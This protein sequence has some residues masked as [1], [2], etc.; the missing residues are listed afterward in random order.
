MNITF[1]GGGNMAGA[2]IGGLLHQG[3]D[4]GAIQVVEIDAAARA[5]LEREYRIATVAAVTAAT[6]RA[7]CIVLAV[8]PQHVREV[9]RLLK[10][11]LAAQLVVSIAAGIRLAD[12]GRWLGG[13]PRLVRVMPNTPALVR[14]GVAGL[15]APG[16]VSAADRERAAR[17][18]GAVGAALWLETEEQM[19]AVT[20]IS[21]SGPAYVFYFI[22][23][24]Q[25]AAVDLGL[26]ASI[27]RRLALETFAGSVRLAMQSDEE[28]A[29]LRSRVTSKGGTTERAVA[30]LEQEGLRAIMTR[31]ARAAAQRSRELGAELGG[32]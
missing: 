20:A 1:V 15:Y 22:E 27:A 14:A 28:P 4:A 5:R 21:G 9:A 13:Y 6:A 32:E 19:D 3:W 17:I 26:D 7:D 8:K 2:M 29:V 23:T 18:M 11:H 10:P 16:S 12:L 30:V 24:L 25:Q 31:A